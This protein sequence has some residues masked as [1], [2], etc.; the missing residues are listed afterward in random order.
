MDKKLN[1]IQRL[2]APTPDLFKKVSKIGIALGIVGGAI[3]GIPATVVVLPGVIIT[4][5]GYLV[6]TGSVAAI[7]AKITVDW[8]KIGQ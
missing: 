7:I 8:D 6:A 4:I 5:G 3:V 2:K 1:I